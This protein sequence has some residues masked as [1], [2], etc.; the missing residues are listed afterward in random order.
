MSGPTAPRPALEDPGR[1]LTPAFR[2]LA[3]CL[4]EEARLVEA[5]RDALLQQRAA[6]AADRP[7]AIQAG[8]EEMA[9]ILLA[10]AETRRR[11]SER[12]ADL[13]GDGATP[14]DR[15]ADILGVPLPPAVESA[16]LHLRRLASDTAREAAI[17]REV[18]RRAIEA[19]DAFIQQLFSG[20][21]P[22]STAYG[23]AEARRG[24]GPRRGFL[25]NRRA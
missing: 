19:G 24:E 23:S 22:P 14:M 2:E 17:N 15:V 3:E 4:E 9:R 1:T 11:R 6:V 20:A 12:L 13:C 10:L 8:V 25:L 16:R 5:L 18:L 7:E 21:A